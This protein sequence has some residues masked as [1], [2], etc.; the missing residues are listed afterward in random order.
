MFR[1]A[2]RNVS[3]HKARLLMT[4]FAVMLGVTFISGSLVYGDSMN[5]AAT[6]RATAGFDRIAVSVFAEN[7]RA[8]GA[9][10]AGLDA[11]TVRALAK[12]EGVAAASGRVGGFAAVAGKDG[13][14]LGHG[15]SHK[16]ANFTPGADGQ[17]PA[18]RFTQGSG[19]TRDD[20]IALDETTAAKGG[21]RVGDTVRAGTNEGAASYTLSGIFRTDAAARAA[22]GS[23]T[24]FTDATAQRLFLQPGRFENIELTAAPGTGAQQLLGRV[25]AML[26]KGAGAATG[27]QLARIQANLATS[28]SDTMSQILLG[29]AAVALFVA[30]FLIS[31]TFTMLVARRTRELALMRAVG[32]S[33]KQVRRILLTE[34]LLVGALASAAGLAL[35]TGAAV[36]LQS[37]FATD[38]APAAPLVLTPATVCVSLL[39]GTLLPM[40]AAWLPVRRAMA[41]PPVAALGAAEP[42]APA[43]TGSL[44]SGLSAALVLTGTAAVVYGALTTGKDSRSVI[45]LGAALTLAGAIGF[46]PLLSRPFAA[47]LRPLLTRVHPVYGNLAVRNTVRDPRRT[48]ATAA[49]LAIALTLASGLSVLGASAAQYL[50][51]ATTHDFAA[52]YLVKPV[53]GGAGMTPVTAAPLKKLPGV[54][55]SPLNQSTE[56]RLAGAPSVLTGVDPATIGRLLRY[57]VTEGSLDRLAQGQ[58]AVADFK[59]KK[60]GWHIGQ[61]LPL[62]RPTGQDNQRGSVTIGAVY[63]ADEQSNLLPSIT[64]P[65]ALV[66]RYDP[67]PHTNGILLATDGGPGRAALAQVTHALGDNPALAVLDATDLRAQDSGSI[68]DQLNVF[69]ALLSM[70]LTIAAL[71]IANTLA[72]SVL[73]RR[74]EI[75]TLR[76]LGVDRAGVARMIRLEALV[77]GAL[78]ATVGT[79][80]GV[81]LGWALGRTLQESVAGYTLVLPW[82]RLALGVLIAMTGALLASLWPA[83]RA[84]RVD[85]PA[86]MTA[87]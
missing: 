31:N 56:Y 44:R 80:L 69:Y 42:A 52:D 83:R 60:E 46:I 28:D 61:T 3:A 20:R 59:A 18:Y 50:D 48:G 68:G 1:T 37:I 66:A 75:G 25:E 47:L 77:L 55:F 78:G 86:A 39:V 12:V 58:I 33:R 63:R 15:P 87:Q 45:G 19:P 26:P 74:K 84:A 40:A 67:T 5:R 29:F 82:G 17:D 57:D 21:Y 53:E 10:P 7:S 49:A 51:R 73:E 27:A 85:I 62:E 41:I 2:L 72:M 38:S 13:R 14:P 6:A 9:P 70:A 16:A 65:D 79:V 76:A 64:A 71:G 36:L 11:A 30:T 22:G 81:F 34:S 32:A 8:G 43:R 23:L 4:A 35:G 24:L 54:A